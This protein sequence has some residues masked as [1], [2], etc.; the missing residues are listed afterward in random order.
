[1]SITV[2]GA[3]D[4]LIEIEGDITEEFYVYGVPESESVLAFSNGVVL[5][6]FYTESGIWRIST[7]TK[8]SGIDIAKIE[9]PEDDDDNYSDR[10]TVPGSIKWVVK[11]DGDA[12]I[13]AV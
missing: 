6:A 11:G 10:V 9:A 7:I 4:D 2:Y 1:M 3:S 8:P 13:K 12:F 5:R